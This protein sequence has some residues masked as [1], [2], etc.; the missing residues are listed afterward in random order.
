MPVQG[1]RRGWQANP[2]PHTPRADGVTLLTPHC[3]ETAALALKHRCPY[4][5]PTQVGWVS[6]LR[7][8]GNSPQGTRQVAPVPSEEG[9]PVEVKPSRRKPL[10]VAETGRCRLFT[11]NTG[12]RKPVRGCMW[13]EAWPVPV[14]EG[15]GCKPQ[16]EARVNAGRNSDGPKVAFAA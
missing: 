5:K 9:G 10:R 16:T 7:R 15:A 1:S 14:G 8:R 13:S 11:K 6:S 3:R 2:S 12:L 4:R